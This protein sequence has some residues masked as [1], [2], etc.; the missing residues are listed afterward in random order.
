MWV[1][2][3]DWLRKGNGL[4]WLNRVFGMSVLGVV[5]FSFYFLLFRVVYNLFGSF[6]CCMFEWVW[7]VFCYNIVGSMLVYFF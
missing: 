1:I 4:C 3:C 5:S 2:V 6:F 7:N